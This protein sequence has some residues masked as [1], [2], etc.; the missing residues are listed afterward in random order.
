MTTHDLIRKSMLYERA[1]GKVNEILKMLQ[2]QR[3]V[4]RKYS[5]MAHEEPDDSYD[6]VYDELAKVRFRFRNFSDDLWC[7]AERKGL[8]EKESV[9]ELLSAVVLRA[10]N[11]YEMAVSGGK[12]EKEMQRIEQ[13]AEEDAS[14]FTKIPFSEVLVKIR[15]AQPE[16]ARIARD[17]AKEIIAET[18]ANRRKRRADMSNNKYR[19]PLCG[20]GLY[21]Q[22][23]R[24]MTYH[25]ICCTG[26]SLREVVSVAKRKA[27]DGKS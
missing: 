10:A 17:N 2:E 15:K 20:G 19:C 12:N 3:K 25:I 26:C 4:D 14:G 8:F 9:E 11:D 16:F 6:L 27:G 13:F 24:G 22:S 21:S 7:G 23:K 18:D 1:Y 5:K